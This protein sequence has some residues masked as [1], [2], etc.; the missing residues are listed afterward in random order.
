ML[1]T[2]SKP[3]EGGYFPE[4]V[5]AETIKRDYFQPS[6][7]TLVISAEICDLYEYMMLARSFEGKYE[8]DISTSRVFITIS[9]GYISE[10]QF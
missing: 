3:T 9:A 6:E 2:L 10:I 5:N 4:T 1:V 7:I 8:Y